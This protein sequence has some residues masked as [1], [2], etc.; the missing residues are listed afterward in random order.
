[1]TINKA[2]THLT[3]LPNFGIIEEWKRNAT[4]VKRA[5]NLTQNTQRNKE[6]GVSF[7]VEN[8]KE[9][10]EIKATQ[11]PLGIKG[12]IV[13][14]L[15]NVQFAVPQINMFHFIRSLLGCFVIGIT[16]I[17]DSMEKLFGEMK[18]LLSLPL[19]GVSDIQKREQIGEKE[20]TNGMTTL[21]RYVGLGVRSW[22]QTIIQ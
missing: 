7:A 1:M 21:V 16:I 18:D 2:K 8:V 14:S 22:K 5:I 9:L 4:S 3:A 20:Y 13:Q 19:Q 12:Y 17:S 11:K 10:E 15:V 6:R